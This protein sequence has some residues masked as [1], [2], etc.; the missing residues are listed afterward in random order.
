MSNQLLQQN[1]REEVLQNAR[2]VMETALA[3]RSY[4][5]SQV[6]SLLQTQM[7]YGPA[8]GF[9]WQ[10]NEII[11]AQ[12]VSVPTE[13]PD[14][15]AAA[16]YR[17]F[18]LSLACVFIFIGLA[19]NLIPLAIVIRPVARLAE[20][21]D[22][23][24]LGNMD[25]PDSYARGKDEIGVLAD[26]F[27]RMEKSVVQAMKLL[28]ERRNGHSGHRE[29]SERRDLPDET[30]LCVLAFLRG[31]RARPFF[32]VQRRLHSAV[33]FAGPALSRAISVFVG[34]R[35]ASTLRGA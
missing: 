1:A 6:G 29:R 5:S 32:L 34:R 9:G 4:T 30:Q 33:M 2:R 19:L 24:S 31:L 22:Q 3:R 17:T 8:N 23:V 18:M 27:N 10:L 15:R 25:V 20:L 16:A 14:Q 12:A 21:A 7:K 35:Q 11:G 13:V 26:S 28:E